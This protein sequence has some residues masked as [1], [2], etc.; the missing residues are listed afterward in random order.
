MPGC[1]AAAFAKT[2]SV[3]GV[4]YCHGGVGAVVLS[5]VSQPVPL[6]TA[7]AYGKGWPELST[8]ND[9]VIV[10]WFPYAA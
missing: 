5:A 4:K 10:A 1:S 3:P 6:L 2:R 9:W 7:T 8:L